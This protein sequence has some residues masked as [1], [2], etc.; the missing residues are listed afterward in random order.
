VKEDLKVP[1]TRKECLKGLMGKINLK[2]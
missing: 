1:R 2:I